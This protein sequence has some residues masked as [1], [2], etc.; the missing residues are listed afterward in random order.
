MFPAVTRNGVSS[1]SS[2]GDAGFQITVTTPWPT[3]TLSTSTLAP[4]TDARDRPVQAPIAATLKSVGK[5]QV[6]INFATASDRIEASS[7]PVLKECACFDTLR[8]NGRGVPF[9]KESAT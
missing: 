5:V 2:S 7:A 4:A 6:Y 3:P 8:P 9:G 1:S